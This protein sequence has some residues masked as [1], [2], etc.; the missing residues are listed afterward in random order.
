MKFKLYTTQ[1]NEY[2]EIRIKDI[3]IFGIH[4]FEGQYFIREEIGLGSTVK[5]EVLHTPFPTKEAIV[6][7]CMNHHKSL[8]L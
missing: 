2:L 1:N 6:E 4:F 8:S 7:S 5:K 3:V